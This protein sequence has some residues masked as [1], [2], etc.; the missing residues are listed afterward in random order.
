MACAG[1]MF[2]FNPKV[3]GKVQANDAT[4]Y[5]GVILCAILRLVPSISVL[6]LDNGTLPCGSTYRVKIYSSVYQ[7]RNNQLKLALDYIVQRYISI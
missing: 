3:L 7:S 1:M 5:N 2:K 6:S 4:V